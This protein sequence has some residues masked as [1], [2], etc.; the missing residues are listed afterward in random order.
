MSSNYLDAAQTTANNLYSPYVTNAGTDFNNYRGWG[1]NAQSQ[2]S[3]ETGGQDP[4][5]WMNQ[6]ISANPMDMYN[7]IMGGW[8]MSTAAQQQMNQQLDAANNAAAQSGMLGSGENIT[9][10]MTIAQNITAQDQ[11]QYLRDIGQINNQQMDWLKG[12]RGEQNSLGKMFSNMLGTEFDASKDLAD[13]TFRIQDAGQRYQSEQDRQNNS[14]ISGLL[15]DT[16]GLVGNIF[17]PKKK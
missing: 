11:Q 12:Y 17:A 14:M 10:N 15:G 13:I 3:G 8:T 4:A 7:Q 16:A 5:T 9:Q 2:L 1:Y 6:G